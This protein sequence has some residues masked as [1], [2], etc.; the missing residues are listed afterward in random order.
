MEPKAHVSHKMRTMSTHMLWLSAIKT[1]LKFEWFIMIIGGQVLG[2]YLVR[3]DG[4]QDLVIVDRIGCI[5]VQAIH[6]G[7]Q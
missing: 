3:L 5:V 2:Q 7:R 6:G 4:H 1:F